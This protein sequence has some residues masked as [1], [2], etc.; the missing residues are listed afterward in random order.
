MDLYR[1]GDKVISR[2]KL[3]VAT[4]AIIASRAEGATQEEAA[5]LAGVTRSFVS[6]L[7]TLGEVRRGSRI[8]LIAFP[9]ENDDEVRA[10]AEEYALDFV[11]V[12]S[13][14]QRESLE[15]ASSGDLFNRLLDT[16]ATLKEFDML[17]TFASDWR[18]ETF[19]RILDIDVVGICLG[20][21]PLRH[22]QH[23]DIVKLRS[24]LDVLLS[25]DDVSIGAGDGGQHRTVKSPRGPRA[26]TSLTKG[27]NPSKK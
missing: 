6:N 27:W 23:V 8:A 17:V 12:F 15:T 4:D 20:E 25:K 14:E 2:D 11:L 3:I 22:D 21:S 13:Q 24:M 5:A 1:I 10:V 18:I 16:L 19:K 9:I 7:E 26:A